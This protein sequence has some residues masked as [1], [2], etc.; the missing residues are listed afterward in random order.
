[1]NRPPDILV[2]ERPSEWIK[3]TCIIPAE[4]FQVFDAARTRLEREGVTHPNEQVQ[5]GMVL[6]IMAAEFLAS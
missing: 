6:E 4:S 5:N 2:G 1:M 3:V